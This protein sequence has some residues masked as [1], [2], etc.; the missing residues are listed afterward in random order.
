MSWLK[1][2]MRTSSPPV[3]PTAA[4]ARPSCTLPAE[5]PGA[6]STA[7]SR[8]VEADRCALTLTVADSTR[9][10]ASPTTEPTSIPDESARA[11]SE[12]SLSRSARASSSSCSPLSERTVVKER[13]RWRDEL[14]SIPVLKVELARRFTYSAP[15][16]C[17]TLS[18]WPG[19]SS[20][21]ATLSDHMRNE[22]RV[23]TSPSCAASSCSSIRSRA[24]CASS[25]VSPHPKALVALASV[26]FGVAEVL[27]AHGRSTAT[28]SSAERERTSWCTVS[29]SPTAAARLIRSMTEA[30]FGSSRARL[31][32]VQRPTASASVAAEYWSATRTEKSQMPA[33]RKA[34]RLAVSRSSPSSSV[35]SER[36]SK[37]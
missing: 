23:G 9:S 16:N 13:V 5:R 2:T 7:S 27:T 30:S 15:S 26:A 11:A 22:S 36:D 25:I 35:C 4:A 34:S 37:E 21:A 8:S 6:S 20:T 33:G 17:A 18:S 32:T 10:G 31:A 12:M 24:P 28:V 14:A 1:T 19:I 3:P 29:D